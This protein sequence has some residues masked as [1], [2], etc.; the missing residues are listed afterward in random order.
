MKAEN[1]SKIN[2]F[3]SSPKSKKLNFSDLKKKVVPDEK[4]HVETNYREFIE[5]NE[6]GKKNK[7]NLNFTYSFSKK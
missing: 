7:R 1:F 4:F 3:G 2:A 6:D 5:R